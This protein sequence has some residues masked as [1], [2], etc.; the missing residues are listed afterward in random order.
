MVSRYETSEWKAIANHP[1]ARRKTCTEE[2][3]LSEWWRR[4]RIELPVQT[5]PRGGVYECSHQLFHVNA[6]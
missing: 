5:M 4:G 2:F 6:L 3:I 1:I